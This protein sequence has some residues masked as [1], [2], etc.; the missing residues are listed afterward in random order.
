MITHLWQL[1]LAI[2]VPAA[3]TLAVLHFPTR[4]GD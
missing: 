1:L 3:V 4:G 2:F